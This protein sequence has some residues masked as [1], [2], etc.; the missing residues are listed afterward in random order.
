MP[1]SS[2]TIQLPAWLTRPE[3]LRR[4]LGVGMAVMVLLLTAC[5]ASPTLHEGMHCAGETGSD[6]ECAV[7]LF[8]NGVA[9]PVELTHLRA[10]LVGA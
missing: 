8:A 1:Q 2:A 9:L 3:H 7:V 10:D 5:G 6:D 4:I